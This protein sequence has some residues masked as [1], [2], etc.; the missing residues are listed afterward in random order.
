MGIEKSN[1]NNYKIEKILKNKYNIEIKNIAQINRG[2]ANIYKIE[3]IDDKYI[4]KEFSIKKPKEVIEKEIDVINFLNGKSIKV[5]VYVKTKD[6][7]LYIENEK[8][9]II[10]Q[11][12]IEGYTIKNNEGNYDQTI[13][14][15]RILGKL[16]KELKEYKGLS[17]EGIIEKWFSKNSIEKGINAIN[18]L[19]ENIKEDN[20]YKE[21]IEKDL[22]DKLKIAKELREKFNFDI[23]RK[24]TILNSHGDYSVQQLIYSKDD[25]T[26]IDFETAKKLPIAWE[27]IRSYSYI[28]KNAKNGKL[29]LKILE[30]YFLEF[31]KYIKLNQYDLKY[32]PHIYLIQIVG[33]IFGYKEYNE[34]YDKIEL[35]DF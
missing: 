12:Y 20:P 29:D 19:L 1:L 4:L 9:I 27:V 30:K 26:V 13:Q 24:M 16:T 3:G 22:K 10:L 6:E 23:I 2:S 33:S 7:K 11:K 5:P 14:S 17:E 15:A 34:N 8:R 28:D 25:V 18:N 31:M 32:A 35:L 21:K